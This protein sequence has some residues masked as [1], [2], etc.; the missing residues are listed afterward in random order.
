MSKQVNFNLDEESEIQF[1]LSIKG[2]TNLPD[3]KPVIRFIIS[4]NNENG[5]SVALPAVATSEG[6]AVTIPP[7]KKI[8]SEDKEYTGKLEIIVGNRYFAPIEMNIGFTSP[9]DIKAES[10]VLKTSAGPKAPVAD[11][12]DD[13]P[14]DV[15][16]A[17]EKDFAEERQQIVEQMP[18]PVKEEKKEP[19]P[20]VSEPAKKAPPYKEK[21]KNLLR[22]ALK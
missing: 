7:L 21:F 15:L 8:F 13:I 4:E 1:K 20:A 11:S 10:V 9:V 12:I 18:A 5:M 6:A 19:A 22:D 16:D 17:L 14:D 3:V 2:S